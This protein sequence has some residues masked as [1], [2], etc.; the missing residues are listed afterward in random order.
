MISDDYPGVMDLGGRVTRQGQP[1]LTACVRTPWCQDTAGDT[2]FVH[3]LKMVSVRFLHCKIIIFPF[4]YAIYQ[5]QS[6]NPAQ[7]QG[8]REVKSHLS[9]GGVPDNLQ[10]YVKATYSN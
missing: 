4:L 3:F 10:T 8:G 1:L 2:V 5:K 6:L 7:I 9:E